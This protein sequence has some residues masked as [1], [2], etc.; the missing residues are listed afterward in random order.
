[1]KLTKKEQSVISFL[2]EQKAGTKDE[3]CQKFEIS[4][5]TVVRA[6]AKYGYY[7]SFN[8][9]SSYYT[10]I[11]IPEFDD[12]GLWFYNDIG[13]SKHKNIDLTIISLVE[14]SLEGYTEKD[15]NNILRTK[16]GDVLRRLY[17][18]NRL[19]KMKIARKIVYL[20]SNNEQKDKQ[21]KAFEQRKREEDIKTQR[22]NFSHGALPAGID[23]G[24]VILTLVLLIEQPNSSIASLSRSLQGKKVEVTAEQIRIIMDFYGVK[25][26]LELSR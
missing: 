10:L 14:N 22:Y 26:K 3:M 6:M 1:M 15:L 19:N 2:S 8:K 9:N 4:P 7:S 25:K 17:R 16:T 23:F 11:D 24:T 12:Q 21:A 13:F 20:S 5:I 18:Q